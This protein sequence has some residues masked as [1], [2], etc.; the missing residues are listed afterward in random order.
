M[1]GRWVGLHGFWGRTCMPPTIS[2]SRHA[3]LIEALR[4]GLRQV[5][6][7]PTWLVI[8]TPGENLDLCQRFLSGLLP[9][10][11]KFAGRTARLPAGGALSIAAA[12]EQVFLPTGTPFSAMF[13]GWGDCD[14]AQM[15]DMLRWKGA[16]SGIVSKVDHD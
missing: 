12:E 3:N 1:S 16:A 2:S 8:V 7:N 15:G 5:K 6:G 13:V 14:K 4:F 11:A 9:L 10:D